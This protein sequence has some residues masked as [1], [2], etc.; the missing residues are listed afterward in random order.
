MVNTKLDIHICG[1][2]SVFHFDPHPYYG[3]IMVIR[4]WE[5][6]VELPPRIGKYRTVP[7]CEF[8]DDEM[9]PQRI[10]DSA[11]NFYLFG[12]CSLSLSYIYG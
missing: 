11:T 9:F 12:V 4:F 5:C 3:D 8:Q 2:T 7:G 1:P 6:S 10:L